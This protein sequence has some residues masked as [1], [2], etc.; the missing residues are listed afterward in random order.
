MATTLEKCDLGSLYDSFGIYYSDLT[1]M[2]SSMRLSP[3]TLLGKEEAKKIRT[4]VQSI[5]DKP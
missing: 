5:L 3:T 4:I 1:E 2:F